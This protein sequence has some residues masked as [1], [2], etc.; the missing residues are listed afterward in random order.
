MSSTVQSSRASEQSSRASEPEDEDKYSSRSEE[1]EESEALDQPVTA[2]CWERPRRC[3]FKSLELTEY[4]TDFSRVRCDMRKRCLPITACGAK[5]PENPRGPHGIILHWRV[6][7]SI[8]TVFAVFRVSDSILQYPRALCDTAV[9][10][11]VNT[12]YRY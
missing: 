9:F 7:C 1:S 4:F 8:S 12:Q 6:L 5:A 3:A 11:T 2:S 10:N